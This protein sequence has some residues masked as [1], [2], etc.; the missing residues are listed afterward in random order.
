ML[1][2]GKLREEDCSKSEA[3]L[4]CRVR[5]GANERA[6]QIKVLAGEPNDINPSLLW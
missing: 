3:N 1:A 4:G 2:L 5:L 6:S